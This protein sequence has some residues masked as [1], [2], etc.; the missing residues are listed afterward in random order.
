MLRVCVGRLQWRDSSV[1]QIAETSVDQ[2]EYPIA[3]STRS[4]TSSPDAIG[5]TNKGAYVAAN[6]A[7]EFD[8]GTSLSTVTSCDLHPQTTEL[9]MKLASAAGVH[10]D[11]K[12]EFE[13][14]DASVVVRHMPIVLFTDDVDE[15]RVW[16]N[17]SVVNGHVK[18]PQKPADV[19]AKPPILMSPAYLGFAV[20]PYEKRYLHFAGVGMLFA[21]PRGASFMQPSIDTMLVC[22]GLKRLFER[23]GAPE[24][25]RAIDIGCGSGFLGKFAAAWAPGRGPLDMTLVDIDAGAADF[26]QS[27]GFAAPST[28]AEGRPVVW[29]HRTCDAVELLQS[30]SDY[31]LLISNPPYIPTKREV[32]GE[33]AL[34]ARS[35]FW[36]GVGLVVHLLKLIASDQAVAGAHLVLALS[37]LTLTAPVVRRTLDAAKDEGCRIRVLVEREIGWKAWYAGSGSTDHLLAVGKDCSERRKI[38]GCEF[39]VGATS[40]GDARF[41]ETRGFDVRYGYHWH[42]AYVLEVT[43]VC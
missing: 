14:F 19:R 12:D 5:R 21:R 38:G 1:E 29:H 8:A 25:R 13:V 9:R 4:R 18:V 34:N 7:V 30:D 15:Q 42:V 43:R 22:L 3:H 32:R 23:D 31:D 26:C 37:S 36:E 27:P 28:G 39:F 17:G 40:P 35:G 10:N 20:E 6:Q 2:T 41:V 24:V 33:E 11:A 16:Y